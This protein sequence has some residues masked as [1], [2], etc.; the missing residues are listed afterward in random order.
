MLMGSSG[1]PREFGFS[2]NNLVK[3]NFP[4]IDPRDKNVMLPNPY[5]LRLRGFFDERKSIIGTLRFSDWNVF[6]NF[7]NIIFTLSIK[8]ALIFY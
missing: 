8:I 7:S 3:S 1:T 6:V 4:N 2:R 5:G